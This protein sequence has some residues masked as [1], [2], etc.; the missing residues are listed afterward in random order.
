MGYP[1]TFSE[2]FELGTRGNFDATSGSL[3]DVPH[4]T[5]L[6]RAGMAPY[7]GSYCLRT[8][9]AA[10]T[11]SQYVREDTG[12]DL[13][14]TNSLFFRWYFYLGKDLTMA[15][16]DKFSLVELESTL[17]TTT[18][19]AA[20]ILYDG[21]NLK[22]WMN[23]TQAAAAPTTFTLGTPAQVLGRWIHAEVKVVI[24]A[25]GGNDGTI[26]AWI[27]DATAGTQI[28]SLDQAAIVDAKF[29]VIGPDAGTSGT[30]L[31]DQIIADD[32]QIYRN[33]ERFRTV[34]VWTYDL[35]DHPIVGPGE[36]SVGITGT[37]TNAVLTIYDT[38]GIPTN[39]TPLA[40]LRNTVANE[41]IP[42]HDIFRVDHGAYITLTGTNAQ[43]FV[44]VT[45]GG[46]T[47]DASYVNRGLKQGRVS[48]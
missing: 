46:M 17:D 4:Y 42:G 40:I 32:T 25:G 33:K 28:A 7:K 22:F 1:W 43:A 9:L 36:F 16:N 6:A 31:I 26:D 2:N 48:P 45:K 30:V 19:A 35:Q 47:S 20:G 15:T 39:L 37:G 44:S 21:T 8:R 41:F 29:G 24:D 5:E 23:E 3:I 10:G 14:A 12:F 38:D 34:N 13:A 11:T 18:E 27:D